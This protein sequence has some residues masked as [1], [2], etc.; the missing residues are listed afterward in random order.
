MRY[1]KDCKHYN[2]LGKWGNSC[3][4]SPVVDDPVHGPYRPSV[5]LRDARKAGGHCG[6]KAMAWE[7]TLWHRLFGERRTK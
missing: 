5:S 6:P 1:C 7:P 3:G 2:S 4:A